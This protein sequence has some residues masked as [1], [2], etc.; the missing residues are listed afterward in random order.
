[1]SVCSNKPIA[2]CREV[3]DSSWKPEP[4]GAC[5]KRLVAFFG[6][7]PTE[8]CKCEARARE[9]DRR[10]ADWADKN[11]DKIVGWLKEEHAAQGSIVPFIDTIARQVVLR[12]IR[13]ARK[14]S[15][16]AE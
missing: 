13:N 5:L 7:K 8:R 10:G 12:A 6:F 1:M 15:A 2:R 9:L 16:H 4:V 14:E 3:R 11:V